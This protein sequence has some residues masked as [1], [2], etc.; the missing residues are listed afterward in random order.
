MPVVSGAIA[1]VTVSADAGEYTVEQCFADYVLSNPQA[2]EYFSYAAWSEFMVPFEEPM[3]PEVLNAVAD[4]E[5]D[6]I[7]LSWDYSP[8]NTNSNLNSRAEVDMQITVYANGLIEVGENIDNETNNGNLDEGIYSFIA[9]D[10]CDNTASADINF[11]IIEITP[12]VSLSSLD[13]ENPSILSEG[14]G[15]STLTFDIPYPYTDSQV[16]NYNIIGSST[17][18]NGDDVELIGKG[19]SGDK[20]SDLLTRYKDDVIKLNPDIVFI[21]IGINDVWHKYDYGTGSD[22]DL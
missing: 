5:V 18:S 19:V 9:V 22:I 20:V 2:Q 17:L 14:C 13:Y 12:T 7:T 21:Y 15:Y 8:E 6:A 3:P 11:E 1:V 4:E 10:E 16:F